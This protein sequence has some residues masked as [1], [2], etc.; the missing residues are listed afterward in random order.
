M[1]AAG[2]PVSPG[3]IEELVL[4][5]DEA[6]SNAVR[7]G[8]GSPTDNT[9][10]TVAAE[11]AGIWVGL[12]YRGEPFDTRVRELPSDCFQLGGRGRFLMH[13]LLDRE[14]YHFTAG[15]TSLRMY[16]RY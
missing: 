14:E 15:M 13:Q 10:V 2:S 9:E 12:H 4:A 5:V 6:F 7:H 3:W 8:T 16:K 11:E 1:V